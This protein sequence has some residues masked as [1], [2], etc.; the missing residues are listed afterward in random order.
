MENENVKVKIIMNIPY[1]KPN[2]NGTIF[3]E[4]A[5][6]NAVNNIPINMPIIC[7]DNTSNFNDK[8]IGHTTGSSHIVIWDFQ[9]QICYITVD[10]VIHCGDIRAII[11]KI[12]D[13]EISDFKI[14][15]IDIII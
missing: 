14:V 6:E 8:V 10:G 13:N 11:N 7:R 1:D 5:V 15:G 12:E 3:T 4:K 9:N 2:K